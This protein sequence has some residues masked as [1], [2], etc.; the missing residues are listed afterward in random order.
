[1]N[2]NL[3]TVSLAIMQSSIIVPHFQHMLCTFDPTYFIDEVHI[4][5]EK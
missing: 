2:K 4:I 1:M 5:T 3:A